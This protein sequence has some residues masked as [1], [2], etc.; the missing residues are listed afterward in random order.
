MCFVYE[1]EPQWEELKYTPGNLIASLPGSERLNRSQNLM[2]F[3]I[4]SSIGVKVWSKSRIS[5]VISNPSS[6]ILSVRGNPAVSTKVG[7]GGPTGITDVLLKLQ[8]SPL[9]TE[10]SSRILPIGAKVL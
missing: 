6:L 8:V 9:T 7:G 4:F 1:I 3:S 5:L 10:N 2:I